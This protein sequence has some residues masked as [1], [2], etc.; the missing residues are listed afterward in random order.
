MKFVQTSLKD[1]LIIEPTVFADERGFF[2]EAF[3]RQRYADAG[4]QYD[5][6]Q[7]NQSLSMKGTLRGLHYQIAHVQ[8]KLVRALKGTVFDVAVDLR[9][10]SPTFGKWVGVTLD[11]EKKNQLWIPPCFA[12]GFYVLSEQA[13]VLYKTT[14]YYD[15]Q[16]ERCIIWNDPH[17]G[18]KWPLDVHAPLLLSSKDQQGI[19]FKHAEVFE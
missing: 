2:M 1:V 8:G 9:R 5:F 10:H 15:P 19:E 14:D 6:V 18:I 12:H 16:A 3:H 11:A 13:E 7:D 17:I 4:I